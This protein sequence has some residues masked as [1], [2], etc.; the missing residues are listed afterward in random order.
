MRRIILETPYKGS[1]WEETEENLRFARLCLHDCFTRGE[2]PFA[3]HLLCTQDGVLNDKILSERMLGIEAGFA[4]KAVADST[5]VYVNRQISTGMHLGIRKAIALGQGVEYRKLSGYENKIIWPTICTFT[6]VSGAGKST[7]V[8][9]LLETIPG[10][11]LVTSLTT[12][13][14]RASDLPNE[15]RYNVSKEWF[16]ES[17]DQFLWM[18]SVHGN[19]YGTLR[20]SVSELFD[21]SANITGAHF[22]ILTS[23]GVSLLRY[24][25]SLLIPNY[26]HRLIHFYIL[27][28]SEEELR[29]R[30]RAR[31]DDYVAI[32][33]RIED[34]KGWGLS[35]LNSQI[36][37]IFISNSESEVGI[38]RAAREISLF[39][40]GDF[41]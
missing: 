35:A 6:G 37:Y 23:E 36:P 24:H 10:T 11:G 1:D 29:R 21:L 28:P 31:G 3:S 30:L 41:K 5:V 32:Q 13:F 8:K 38:D 34:C 2:A 15:Y 14:S 39:L 9:K 40:S 16:E 27:S 7:I 26:E 4:W 12:R 25:L 18:L 19:L 33:K 17:R 22:M 20:G